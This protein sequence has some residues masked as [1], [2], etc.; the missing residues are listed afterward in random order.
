MKRIEKEV[1]RKIVE[2]VVTFEAS[3]GTSFDNVDD[4]RKYENS[5]FC[6][7]KTCFLQVPHIKMERFAGIQFEN[8]DDEIIAVRPRNLD[9]I[10]AINVFIDSMNY[11]PRNKVTQDDVGKTLLFNFGYEGMDGRE[12]YDIIR[13]EEIFARLEENYKWVDE[14]FA[15]KEQ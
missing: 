13:K 2:K 9:D 15:K 12:C 8:E 6:S 5:Y 1:E 14:Q 4:C 7:V 10:H 3:D 11:G